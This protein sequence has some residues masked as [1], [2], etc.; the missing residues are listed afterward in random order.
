MEARTCERCKRTGVGQG[1]KNGTSVTSYRV[2]REGVLVR[3][4]LC[5]R[6]AAT[7]AKWVKP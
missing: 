7:R 1:H 2:Q 5:L 3:M 6:C 4:W